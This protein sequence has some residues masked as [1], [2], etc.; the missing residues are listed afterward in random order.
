MGLS[1]IL[2]KEAPDVRIKGD[3]ERADFVV[4]S[5]RDRPWFRQLPHVL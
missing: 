1:N 3:S 5:W 2:V 4:V